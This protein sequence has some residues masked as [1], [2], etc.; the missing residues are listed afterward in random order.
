MS[1]YVA[2]PPVIERLEKARVELDSGD[3]EDPFP[4]FYA[5]VIE[6]LELAQ[7]RFPRDPDDP[8]I[9][10]ALDLADTVTG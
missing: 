7:R 2:P 8:L 5:A 10:Y 4:G 9:D 6:L 3:H 1:E